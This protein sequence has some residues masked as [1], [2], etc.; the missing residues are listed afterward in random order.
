MWLIDFYSISFDGPFMSSDAMDQLSIDFTTDFN[1][2]TFKLPECTSAK[3]RRKI[4]QG[5]SLM[6]FLRFLTG[7]LTLAR[8]NYCN[9]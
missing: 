6:S 1:N 9:S 7:E 2:A 8:P 3:Q 4:T 5:K